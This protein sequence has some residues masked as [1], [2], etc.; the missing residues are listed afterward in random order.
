MPRL[1]LFSLL[2]LIQ[3]ALAGCAVGNI[4]ALAAKV[5]HLEGAHIID[6]H[7]LGLHVRTRTDDA[8]AQFGY[9]KRRYIFLGRANIKNGWYFFNVPLPDIESLVQDLKILGVEISTVAPDPFICI[10]YQHTTLHARIQP[11]TSFYL[12]YEGNPPRII[13]IRQYKEGKLC[14]TSRFY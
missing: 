12:E 5:Q 4:G 1:I 14:D 13:K 7:A 6:V 8:G 3:A 11:W 9:S 10:G 2:F